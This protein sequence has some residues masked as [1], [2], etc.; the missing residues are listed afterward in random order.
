MLLV[1]C[2]PPLWDAEGMRFT[3][4]F[5][6]HLVGEVP[7]YELGFVPDGSVVDFVR[8]VK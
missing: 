4:D 8:C 1:R 5:C 3:L 6:A 2:F 7:C